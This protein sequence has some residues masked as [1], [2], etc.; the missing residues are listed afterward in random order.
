MSSN[1]LNS[2]MFDSIQTA[3]CVWLQCSVKFLASLSTGPSQYGE[4][5]N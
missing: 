5:F 2:S 1:T 3:D 4:T